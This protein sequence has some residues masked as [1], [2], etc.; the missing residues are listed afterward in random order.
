M[1]KKGLMVLILA[2]FV[3]GWSFSQAELAEHAEPLEQEEPTDQAELAEQEEQAE[4]TAFD[5]MAKNTITV[6][7]GPTITGILIHTIGDRINKETDA[8]YANSSGFG[9]G[10]QYERQLQEKLSVAGRFAYMRGGIGA[11]VKRDT[12]EDDF[13]LDAE[14]TLSS[15]S[16][17]GHVRYYPLGEIFFLD[18]MLGYANLSIGMLGEASGTDDGTYKEEA[19]SLTIPR[20]Y[21]KL[22][23][24]VGWRMSFGNN[25]GFTFESAL[26]WYG[27]IG[28]GETVGQKLKKTVKT[29][30]VPADTVDRYFAEYIENLIFIGGPRLTLALGW[31][32]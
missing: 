30:D 3:A 5:A 12:D 22:G 28:L 2:V 29:V 25:G 17:E 24:K 8:G 31:R 13:E 10:V 1:A 9:I 11:Y 26:G 18:G 27:G 16:L 6:D 15:F 20:N 7:L 14:L 23:A 21:I 19:V 32:F 4:P